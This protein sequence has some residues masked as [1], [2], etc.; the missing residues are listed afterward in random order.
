MTK[1]EIIDE[2]NE[3]DE[4]KELKKLL[5]GS[6][7]FRIL[8]QSHTERWHSAFWSWLFDVNGSHKLGSLPLGYLF[9][10][11]SQLV[12]EDK[13][14][15]T[16][17]P[18]IPKEL[19]ISKIKTKPNEKDNTEETCNNSKFD[20]FIDGQ[21]IFTCIIEYKVGAYFDM[22]Q[23]K[24]YYQISKKNRWSNTIFIYV[25]PETRHE[26]F[27]DFYKD[28][29]DE[30]KVWFCL[31]FQDLYNG[32][33]KRIKKEMNNWDK[34]D[35]NALR[36]NILIDDYTHIM[37]MNQK[38]IKLA[39]SDSELELSMAINNK[40]RGF[41]DDLIRLY[42]KDYPDKSP[43]EFLGD[44]YE[45]IMDISNSLVKKGLKKLFRSA[46]IIE[47]NGITIDEKYYYQVLVSVIDYF[48]EKGLLEKL[49]NLKNDGWRYSND[50]KTKRYTI[51]K[52]N[53]GMDVPK[54]S[55]TGNYYIE[56]K[57]GKTVIQQIIN[58][59]IKELRKYSSE[60]IQIKYV[61]W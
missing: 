57:Y 32:V 8:G 29:E 61:L 18:S 26:E 35:P 34:Q 51:K 11:L 2:L 16:N 37:F 52:T 49:P 1:K 25:V 40:Y 15:K 21:D 9:D 38:G 12:N 55:K 33:I 56:S 4:Y 30:D 23:I 42:E 41:L 10:Y 50:S 24:K 22:K 47:L 53:N 46:P 13:K 45:T 44:E 54:Q 6:N 48:E 3:L 5:N 43:E 39:F 19:D 27:I 31:S 17:Y 58:S 7:L 28:I 14:P 59:L 60:E 36:N 20:T